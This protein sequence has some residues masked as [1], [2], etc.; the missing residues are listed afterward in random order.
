[1][2]LTA[3]ASSVYPSYNGLDTLLNSLTSYSTN[4]TDPS[5]NNY[6]L[7]VGQAITNFMLN[8]GNQGAYNVMANAITQWITN[9]QVP[10]QALYGPISDLSSTDVS[11]LTSFTSGVGCGLRVQI[12]QSSGW[13]AYDSKNIS[14]NTVGKNIYNNIA[15][16]DPSFNTNGKWMINENQNS[17]PYNIGALLSN[18]GTFYYTGFS[19]SVA[20]EQMYVAVRQGNSPNYSLGNI[21]I[22]M[23]VQPVNL[24]TPI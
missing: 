15:L 11:F 20:S 7:T 21:V 12:I 9:Q 14:G 13:T 5:S 18:S 23:N 4:V 3:P 16:P 19:P 6:Q 10:Y 17:R 1:M 24:T 8:Q 22:S 2:V